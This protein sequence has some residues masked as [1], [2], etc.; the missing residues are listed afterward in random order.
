MSPTCSTYLC[1]NGLRSI[2]HLGINKKMNDVVIHY[3]KTEVRVGSG[4][5]SMT[6]LELDQLTLLKKWGKVKAVIA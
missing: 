3:I 4:V 6:F 5:N 2:N 1:E